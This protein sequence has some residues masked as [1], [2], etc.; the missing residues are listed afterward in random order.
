LRN[1]AKNQ[2]TWQESKNVTPLAEEKEEEEEPKI[3]EGAA[4][5]AIPRGLISAEQDLPDLRGRSVLCESMIG[6]QEKR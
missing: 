3:K 2:D 6:R 1:F 5:S 4:L